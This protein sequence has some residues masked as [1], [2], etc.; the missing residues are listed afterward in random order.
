MAT[1]LTSPK[2]YAWNPD[3]GNPL[4]FGKVY[5]FESGT[6]NVPLATYQD[7]LGSVPN[8]HPV[9]LNAAGYAPIYLD[10]TYNIVVHDADDVPVWSHDPVSSGFSGDGGSASEWI[11]P[12]TAVYVGPTSFKVSGNVVDVFPKGRALKIT[13]SS[14]VVTHVDSASYGSGYTTVTI[15]GS[16]ALDS[17]VSGVQVG[18]ITTYPLALFSTNVAVA[19]GAVVGSRSAAIFKFTGVAGGTTSYLDGIDGLTGGPVI[20]GSAT[21]LQAGDIAFVCAGGIVTTYEMDESGASAD[22]TSIIAPN[23]NPGL[24]RW[25]RRVSYVDQSAICQLI[26]PIGSIVSLYV[27]TSPATL[28]GFGTWVAHGAGRVPVCLTSSDTDFDTVGETGGVKTVTLSAAQ[29]GAPVH[30]HTAGTQS[31]EHSHIGTTSSNGNH[32]HTVAASTLTTGGVP[33]LAATITSGYPWSVSDSGAHTHT[34]TTG[35]E[36][37]SHTHTIANNSAASAAE[38]HTNMPPYIVE[39]RWRRTA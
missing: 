27:S 17:G 14:T 18:L 22:G 9:I 37:Q 21:P 7:E 34:M 35:S 36:S 1:V 16:S 3:T 28:F 8:T 26:Y 6:S 19:G 5:A 10:G 25:R 24:R 32:N 30:S 4:A 31:V 38:A 11:L 15:F 13:G 12:M 2:F 33:G 23:S 20:N 29:S 39:Y